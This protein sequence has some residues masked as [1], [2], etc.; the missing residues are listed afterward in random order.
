MNWF[1]NIWNHPKTSVAGVL[2]AVV[3]V[4]GVLSQ[5][6]ITLGTAGTGTVV[7]LIGAL[8]TALLGLFAQDPTQPSS[9]TVGTKL[10]VLLLLALL[11]PAGM[12]GLVGCT[13]SQV[14]QV[15]SEID[16]YLPTA[17][18]L[19]NEAITI[20]SAVG[21]STSS[22]STAKVTAALSTVEADLIALETPLSDYLAATSSAS[23]T[24]AWSNIEAA[25][26]TAVNDADTLLAVAK[27]SDPTSAATGTVVI[28]SLDAAIHTIDAFVSSAQTSTQVSAK[29]AK[30]SAKLA[31]VERS[32][33]AADKQHIAAATGVPYAL[34]HERALAVGY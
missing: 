28:A 26:D 20:Y 15:V 23:K 13:G 17:V 27:V 24:T 30:R 21:S 12:M 19:L 29:L 34:L 18:S 33:S 16:T 14:N 5:Q 25:V 2:V 10:G 9:T 31:Q 3:T 22:T 7:T 4:A 8:A 32:W 11:L 6:G 1:A